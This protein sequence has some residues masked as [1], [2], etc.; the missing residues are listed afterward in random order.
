[1]FDVL[2]YQKGGALLR[3]LE[4]YL[5]EERFRAGIRH[6]LPHPRVRQHR[7][8]RPVGRDRGDR[9]ASRCGG[10]WTLDLAAGLPARLA[11]SLD[12]DELVLAPAALPF[13]ADDSTRRRRRGRPGAR[14]RRR[15]HQRSVLLDDDAGCGVPARRPDGAGRRQRRRPRLLPRRLR[16]RA[17][18]PARRRGARLADTVER[19]NLVDDAW[20]AVVAGRLAAADFLAF[21][22]RVRATS[23]TSPSGRR[24]SSACAV[25][26]GSSATTRYDAL[27]GALRA[28]LVAPALADSAGA[29]RRRGRP[30]RQAPRAARR[31]RSP[32]SATTPAT[33]A[34]CRELFDAASRDATTVDPGTGRRRPRSVVAATGDADDLRPSRALPQRRRHRRSSSATCTRW[35]IRRRGACRA[36]WSSRC[37]ATVKTQNAPFVLA[38][39]SPTATTG[40]R[41]GASSAS[42][43]TRPTSGSRTTPSCA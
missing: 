16:R 15:R 2:T 14:P 11:P 24:S 17:A 25:S 32:C 19:Y 39:A 21:A 42:T 35:P 43:G 22:R 13:D 18:R 20:A 34:R 9:P 26:A 37:A 30:H 10:S 12:G 38:R 3:M 36:R 23:P 28:P 40:P 7:D 4:Q 5:G 27:P 33:Q 41:P 29:G 8:D 1:M 6:Y 31:R